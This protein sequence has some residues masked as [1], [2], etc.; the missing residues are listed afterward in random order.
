MAMDGKV[1]SSGWGRAGWLLGAL[2]A[3]SWPRT[4][5]AMVGLIAVPGMLLQTGGQ[6]PPAPPPPP[7]RGSAVL[8]VW[9]DAG[10]P[11]DRLYISGTGLRPNVRV[12]FL[13]ACPYFGHADMMRYHNYELVAGTRTDADGEILDF[14]L[15]AIHLQGLPTSLCTIYAVSLNNGSFVADLNALYRVLAPDTPLPY[16]STHIV[17]SV[18]LSGKVVKT[19]TA[20]RV[21][22][23]S[24]CSGA[25]VDI[26]LT[27]AHMQE[28]TIR[29][30]LDAEGMYQGTLPISGAEEQVGPVH[31]RASFHLG[32]ARGTTSTSFLV[33]H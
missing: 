20:E 9:P 6:K 33:V 32:R 8:R 7:L 19:G 15:R 30:R 14:P 3:V 11:G 22:I 4:P 10:H 29:V 17:G 28:K 2:R 27:Y 23:T 26:L 18:H 16:T 31:V 24:R 12:N 21:T 13:T 25:Y 1:G 5:A